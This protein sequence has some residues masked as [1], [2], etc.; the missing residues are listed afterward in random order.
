M[1]GIRSLQEE[2]TAASGRLRARGGAS[3]GRAGRLRSVCARRGQAVAGIGPSPG[4]RR[5]GGWCGQCWPAMC[6][7]R[8]G[9]PGRCG[10]WR[11]SGAASAARTSRSVPSGHLPGRPGPARCGRNDA[12]TGGP[13]A[14]SAWIGHGARDACEADQQAVRARVVR[15]RGRVRHR[16]A[17]RGLDRPAGW[18]DAAGGHRQRH[19]SAPV[20]LPL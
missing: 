9:G 1:R 17:H 18:G 19:R 20:D 7:R 6:G 13:G 3:F 14:A 2:G 16:L 10:R 4:H 15:G 5:A 8:C 12:G 11:S